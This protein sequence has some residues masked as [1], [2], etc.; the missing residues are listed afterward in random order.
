MVDSATRRALDAAIA[1]LRG[2][3]AAPVDVVATGASSTIGQRA[4]AVAIGE[5]GTHEVAGPGANPR[6]VQYLDGCERGGHPLGL[7]GDEPA[8]CAALKGFCEHAAAQPGDVVAPW[9][10]AVSE[11][12]ADAVKAGKARAKTWAPR[13]GDCAVFARA[14]GDPRNGGPGHIARVEVVPNAVG[15]YAAIG[16]NESDQVKRT[17]RNTTDPSLVG[18]IEV[19]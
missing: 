7:T 13:V 11:C 14:G 10:A 3:G 1:S 16:G 8:W 17:L 9:R 4:L 2:K 18:W 15:E 12:W 19:G 6:I 5:L